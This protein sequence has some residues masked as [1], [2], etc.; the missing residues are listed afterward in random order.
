[1]LNHGEVQGGGVPGKRGGGRCGG[2]GVLQA[3]NYG[4]ISVL[5]TERQFRTVPST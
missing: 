2:V 3:M 4:T 1:M 5:N